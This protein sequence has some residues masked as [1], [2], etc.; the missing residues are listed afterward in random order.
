MC[1][2]ASTKVKSL[3]VQSCVMV[4]NMTYCMLAVVHRFLQEFQ[5]Q[6][7]ITV[8]GIHTI[9]HTMYIHQKTVSMNADLVWM[10]VKS[11][12]PHLVPYKSHSFTPLKIV[13]LMDR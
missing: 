9:P 3:G 11:D 7:T 13:K 5:H 10:N 1:S 4:Q 6:S 2:S 12:M 8:L